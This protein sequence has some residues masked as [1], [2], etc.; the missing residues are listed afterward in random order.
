MLS[1]SKQSG[2]EESITCPKAARRQ[3]PSA[4]LR[5]KLITAG[6]RKESCHLPQQGALPQCHNE[7]CWGFLSNSLLWEEGNLLWQYS[8]FG[9]FFFSSFPCYLSFFQI[10]LTLAESIPLSSGW[11][12]HAPQYPRDRS[13]FVS[14]GHRGF[15][16]EGEGIKVS[17]LLRGQCTL[18]PWSQNSLILTSLSLSFVSNA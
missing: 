18:V 1:A 8:G 7:A 11:L 3:F 12:H 15:H 2:N 16:T 14:A 9:L 17:A 6:K 4:R 10:S 13:G 5:A